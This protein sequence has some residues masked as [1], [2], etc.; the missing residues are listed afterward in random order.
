MRVVCRSDLR[1][2][3][4]ARLMGCLGFEPQVGQLADGSKVATL[5]V[6]TQR[7]AASEGGLVTDWHR[8]AVF[9]RP[10]ET[11]ADHYRPGQLLYV[12]GEMRNRISPD[13]STI[14]EVAATRIMEVGDPDESG[15]EPPFVAPGQPPF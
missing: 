3:N 7:H 14:T 13:G 1:G 12:V 4:E 10:A 15:A 9:G 2:I 8:V 5:A 11:A 6:Y